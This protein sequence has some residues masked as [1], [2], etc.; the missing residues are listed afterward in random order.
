M[1]KQEFA[2]AWHG[3]GTGYAG[4]HEAKRK[5]NNSF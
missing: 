1:V 3:R 5:N 4:H 2:E